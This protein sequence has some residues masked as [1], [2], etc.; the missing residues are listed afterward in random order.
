MLN[1]KKS[2]HVP[3]KLLIWY[4][5]I[6]KSFILPKYFDLIPKI[7]TVG[8]QTSGPYSG[9]FSPVSFMTVGI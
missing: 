6:A 9:I 1:N 3:I 5:H 8:Y 4:V 7:S 2:K